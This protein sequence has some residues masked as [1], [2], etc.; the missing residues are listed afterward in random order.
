MTGRLS[1]V[2]KD[3]SAF[4]GFFFFFLLLWTLLI[5]VLLCVIIQPGLSCRANAAWD[6]SASPFKTGSA[7]CR[8][9]CQKRLNRSTWRVPFSGS[10]SNFISGVWDGILGG[11]SEGE[12]NRT[13][14]HKRK[15]LGCCY[16]QE[17]WRMSLWYS[18]G[19]SV[20]SQHL[21]ELINI[22]SGQ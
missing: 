6:Y 4:S 8:R 16:S 12:G 19:L 3:N 14:K 15:E 21:C 11:E 1:A 7:G 5:V 18:F 17:K 22:T 10:S 9:M 2:W 13:S 20:K